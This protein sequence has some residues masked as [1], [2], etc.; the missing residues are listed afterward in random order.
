MHIAITG[1]SSGIGAA[2]ARHFAAKGHKL[3]LVARREEHLKKLARALGAANVHVAIHDLADPKQA[4]AWIP[5]AEA[6]LGPIDVLVNNAG[7]QIVGR[8]HEVDPDE[9]ERLFAIDLLSPLR[10]TRAVLPAMIARGA[11]T[12]VDVASMAALAPTPGMTYYNAAKAGLAAASESL[13]GELRGTG[14]HIVTVYPGIIGSTDM[15]KAALEKYEPSAIVSAFP[16]GTEERLAEL[17]LRAIE[18]RV[19]RV[20]YPRS[21]VLSRWFPGTTRW[22]LD[23]LTPR[24]RAVPAVGAVS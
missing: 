7:V 13:R 4:A 18:R 5:A 23:R 6:A 16:Q 8:T 11:G 2:Y 20:I 12:I 9:A 24:L 22:V 3:T 19:D 1:A 17:T 15:A 14:V 10:L 21:G